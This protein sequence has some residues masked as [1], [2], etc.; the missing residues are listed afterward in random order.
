MIVSAVPAEHVSSVWQRVSS[1]LAPGMYRL[2]GRYDL[3]DVLRDLQHHQTSLWIAFDST[4]RVIEGAAVVRI[5]DY[6]KRR[7]ARIEIVGGKR[8]RKWADSILQAIE[9]YARDVGCS[10]VE[11]SGRL[12][13]ER[14]SAPRGFKAAAVFIEKDF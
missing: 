11:A 7:L 4:T 2:G 14:F 1:L 8:L 9:A 3:D 5:A 13:W 10:G 6:P 12:G